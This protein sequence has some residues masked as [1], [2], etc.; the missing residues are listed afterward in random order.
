MIDDLNEIAFNR[1]LGRRLGLLR[2]AYGWTQEQA[3][4]HF[5]CQRAKISN[6]ESGKQKCTAFDLVR[7]AEIYDIAPGDPVAQAFVFAVPKG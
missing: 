6:I 7:F 5:G 2:T 1:E 3:A 4:E